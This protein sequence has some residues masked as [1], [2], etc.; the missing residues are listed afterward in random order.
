MQI[1]IRVGGNDTEE[2]ER[3]RNKLNEIYDDFWEKLEWKLWIEKNFRYTKD[4]MTSKNNI[5]YTNIR[6]QAVAKEV[7]KKLNKNINMN[8]ARF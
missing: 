5:A 2:G 1:C 4:V 6:C 3:N 8:L 7:R